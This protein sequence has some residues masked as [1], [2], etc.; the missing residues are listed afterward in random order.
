MKE[1]ILNQLKEMGFELTDFVDVCYSFQYE[2]TY[3]IYMYDP[4]D[5][6]FL[7]LCVPYVQEIDKDDPQS[8]YELMAHL[9]YVKAYDMGDEIWLFYEHQLFGGE[10]LEE[11]LGSMIRHLDACMDTFRNEWDKMVPW[12]D[13]NDDSDENGD[14]DE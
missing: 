14:A 1:K 8:Y 3:I 5:E 2:C 4:T 10:D 12:D 11:L 9:K 6:D 7:C 13:D